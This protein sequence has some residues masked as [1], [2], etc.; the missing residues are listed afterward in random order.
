VAKKLV[1]KKVIL[2]RLLKWLT[3]LISSYPI[4]RSAVEIVAIILNLLKFRTMNAGKN[5][6]F[7]LCRS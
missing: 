3:T 2:E 5:L 7:L 6:K 1:A 4:L